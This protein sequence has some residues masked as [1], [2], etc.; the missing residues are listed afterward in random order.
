MGSYRRPQTPCMALL[1]FLVWLGACA[2]P[3]GAFAAEVGSVAEEAADVTPGA[4]QTS[5]PATFFTINAVLAKL[6]RERGQGPN[7][8]RLASLAHPSVATDAQPPRQVA[9][10]PGPEP[11]GLF[12]FRAPEGALWRKWRGVESDMMKEQQVLDRCRTG[13]EGCPSY[14]AQFLRLINAVK[15]KTGRAQLDEANRAVNLAIRYVSDWVQHGE[16]DRWSAPLATFATA[17]G[18]CEDYAIAK[19]VALRLAG[20]APEDLRIVIVRDIILGE[21][22]AVAAARL[23]GHWLTLDN[24]RMAMVEDSDARSY[25][26]TFVI[27]PAGVMRYTETPLVAEAALR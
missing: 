14:A 25:R 27:G 3:A 4:D 8:T 6:D 17:K 10:G 23:D 19:F 5:G 7:A 12:T 22:H 21:D 24:R 26:P 2:A 16:I 15:S 11:F 1:V 20:V 13:A 18:D 9:P